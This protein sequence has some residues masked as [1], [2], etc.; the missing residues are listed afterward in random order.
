MRTT[1]NAIRCL[2][3]L[4]ALLSLDAL[5]QAADLLAKS[6]KFSIPPQSL[7]TAL[8]DFAS[9]SGVQFSTA[10]AEI[11][12]IHSNGVSGVRS[13]GEALK[14]LLDGFEVRGSGCEHDCHS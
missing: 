1:I 8:I 14:T 7:S 4:T 11:S 10:T 2:I 6:A 12:E 13:V 3:L 9:Q 5:A